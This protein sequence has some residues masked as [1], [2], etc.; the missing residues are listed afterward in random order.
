MVNNSGRNQTNHIHLTGKCAIAGS[1][2]HLYDYTLYNSS[3]NSKNVI[4]TYAFQDLFSNE[5]GLYDASDLK[6]DF[7]TITSYSC[8]NMFH[9]CSA[10]VYGPKSLDATILDTFCYAAMFYGCGNL[11][12]TPVLKAP[13]ADK[14]NCYESMFNGCSKVNN[15]V[16]YAQTLTGAN[17]IQSWLNGVSATGDFYNLGG[18]TYSSGASGIPSG[19]TEHTSL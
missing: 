13:A 12:T 17:C 18:A 1:I 14:Q 4:Y 8:A 6:M 5:Q 3:S 7:D 19:W 2:M 16:S 11:I 15:I 10:M 9:G